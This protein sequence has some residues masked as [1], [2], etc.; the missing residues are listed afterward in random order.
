MTWLTT[1]VFD[2]DTARDVGWLE[3]VARRA[4]LVEHDFEAVADSDVDSVS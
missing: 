1:A 3:Q 4:R 2:R